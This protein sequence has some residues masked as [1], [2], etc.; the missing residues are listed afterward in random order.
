MSKTWL[1]PGARVHYK[2]SAAWAED[3]GTVVERFTLSA[4]YYY[5]LPDHHASLNDGDKCPKGCYIKRRTG[6]RWGTGVLP[7]VKFTALTPVP[8]FVGVTFDE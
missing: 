2:G 8:K 4:G 7:A 6:R 3:D 1:L 5:F